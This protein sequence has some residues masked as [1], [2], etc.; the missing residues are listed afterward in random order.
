MQVTIYDIA[1][2]ADVS[3]STVSRVVNTKP[4]VKK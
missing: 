3:A 2:M 4:N 1:R